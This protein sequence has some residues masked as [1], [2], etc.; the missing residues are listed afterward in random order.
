MHVAGR[1]A[2]T[3]GRSIKRDRTRRVPILILAIGVCIRFLCPVAYASTNYCFLCS[4]PS[5]SLD[6]A[7]YNLSALGDQVLPV[8]G[9]LTNESISSSYSFP[10]SFL[11]PAWDGTGAGIGTGGTLVGQWSPIAGPPVTTGPGPYFLTASLP[12]LQIALAGHTIQPGES[13]SFPIGSLLPISAPVAAGTYSLSQLTIGFP[14]AA[15]NSADWLSP[16]HPLSVTVVN[17]APVQPMPAPIDLGLPFAPQNGATVNLL[18]Q[19]GGLTQ[20]PTSGLDACGYST[21]YVD[22]C[23]TK[24]E[25]YWAMDFKNPSAAAKVNV[26][27]VHSGTIEEVEPI[28][29]VTSTGTYYYA[30]IVINDGTL[31]LGGKDYFSIYQEFD[32]IKVTS[33]TT[34]G[35][36][37]AQA[38]DA[39]K[40]YDS[41]GN[42]L[43]SGYSC[44]NKTAPIKV[45]QGDVLAPL[46]G[47]VGLNHLHFQMGYGCASGNDYTQCSTSSEPLNNVQIGK[48]Y[49]KQ[50][51]L[52]NFNDWTVVQTKP[53]VGTKAG[54][55]EAISTTTGAPAP[56]ACSVTSGSGCPVPMTPKEMDNRYQYSFDADPSKVF[57]IDPAVATGYDYQILS[58]PLFASAIF[59]LVGN[60]LYDLWSY[61]ATDGEYVFN[62]RVQAGVPFDFGPSGVDRFRI[63]GIDASAAIDPSDPFGFVT[64]LTFTGPGAVSLSQTPL[65][66]P[67]DVPEPDTLALLTPG[68]L[69]LVL[70]RRRCPTPG[71]AGAAA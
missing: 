64:G 42:L 57:Y 66:G 1:L 12:S 40:V 67:A 13:F 62:S 56:E 4:T 20:D 17:A 65:L 6:F 43:C 30:K 58:G 23:H 5:L 21:G 46:A 53:G 59:P 68:V 37:S 39:V 16:V 41:Q 52:A 60:G 2:T 45:G 63:T 51:K 31:N 48:K 50:F 49:L 3:R 11:S 32:P 47:G 27:S 70:V 55:F 8:T 26:V 33:T 34:A 35:E 10:S 71:R 15:A 7:Q 61:D 28:K 36:A 69:A 25:A 44:G 54:S 29:E 18:T 24:N 9:I 19:V 22:T 38:V 14:G